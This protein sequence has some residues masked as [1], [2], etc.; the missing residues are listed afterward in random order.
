V[1]GMNLRVVSPIDLGSVL[2]YFLPFRPLRYSRDLR[3]FNHRRSHPIA[4]CGGTLWSFCPTSASCPS[5][6]CLSTGVP[7]R[8][9]PR[10]KSAS[11]KL[12]APSA[13]PDETTLPLHSLR[14]VEKAYLA[15]S[16]SRPQGLATLSTALARS[17]LGNFFQLPTLLGFPL[18]SFL[19][20]E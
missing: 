11:L 16:K 3:V 18:Q 7:C 15:F 5:A 1:V 8:L 2:A 13:F 6:C 4:S 14:S 9:D 20:P 10:S 17:I 19:P 12:L